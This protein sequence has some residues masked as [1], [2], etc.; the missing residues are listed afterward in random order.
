LSR[1]TSAA[2]EEIANL[3]VPAALL[4]AV[5]DVVAEMQERPDG[6]EAVRARRLAPVDAGR[7]LLRQR[8]GW[9]R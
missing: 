2:C 7:P 8:R 9:A 3:V 6:L 1:T 5:M 4:V